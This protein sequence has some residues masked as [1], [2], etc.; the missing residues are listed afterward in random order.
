MIN[1]SSTRY[2][3]WRK[4]VTEA[5][6]KNEI[7]NSEKLNDLFMYNF[8]EEF[9]WRS[10]LEFVSNRI[11]FSQRQCNDK[12]TKER[13]YRIKN[14]LKEP[15]YEVLYR[16]N[17]NKIEN[18]KCKRC[19]KEEKEDWEH[20]VYGYVK[21]TN[22]RTINEIVQES[23]YRFEKY[24][25][26][27][28]QNEEI[29]ILRTYNFEFIRILESP[30]IILQGKNRIWELLRGVYNENFNSLTKKK[31]EKTL[32]KKLWNF[33]YDELKKKIWIP[34]CDE[35]KRLEDRENIKK[36]DLRKKREITIEE[37]EEEKD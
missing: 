3:E 30:S 28:N 21:I 15:T 2:R 13:T 4:K 29:E 16:R 25:K 27:L 8:K 19:G 23:I 32:I 17:T 35:I 20:T 5:I 1:E 37:L 22:S 14:I 36:L 7:L 34:R 18:D 6:W 26:D 33:T 24:L 10:T 31:E 12:D 9:D 11:N